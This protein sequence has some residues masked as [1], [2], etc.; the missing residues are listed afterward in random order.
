MK[1]RQKQETK[2]K[3][4]R[5]TRRKKERQEKERDRERE[6]EKGGGQK[7]LREKERETLTIN[8]KCPFLGGKTGFFVYYCATPGAEPRHEIFFYFFTVVF[9]KGALPSKH[10]QNSLE[11]FAA[12]SQSTF[13]WQAGDTFWDHCQ[14]NRD[15][16]QA[17]K[18]SPGVRFW[19]GDPANGPGPKI[20]ETG[21]RFF[22]RAFKPIF[23]RKGRH[24]FFANFSR[25]KSRTGRPLFSATP[26]RWVFA[27]L[28]QAIATTAMGQLNL[29]GG[30]INPCIVRDVASG[31]MQF[32][33]TALFVGTLS[34]HN[35][36]ILRWK[37]GLFLV[38]FPSATL[39]AQLLKNKE[40]KAKKKTKTK[41]NRKKIRRV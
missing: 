30:H 38:F 23:L 12:F 41:K 25:K 26:S 21:L 11:G 34:T 5:K 10:H 9:M 40:S 24:F 39:A 19:D 13:C 8:K 20:W 4:R 6:T 14:L 27:Q 36:E 35:S 7:R 1:K 18:T 29:Q 32:Q 22:S 17:E 15:C 3:Q 33:P 28:F 31:S 37:N 2:K 16:C